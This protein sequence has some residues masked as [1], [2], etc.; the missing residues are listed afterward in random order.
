MTTAPPPSAAGRAAARVIAAGGRC[1]R[2]N[3]AAGSSHIQCETCIHHTSYAPITIVHY[4]C[5]VI[6]RQ[7][8]P[9]DCAIDPF[10]NPVY[11]KAPGQ[12]AQVKRTVRVQGNGVNII[13]IGTVNIRNTEIEVRIVVQI[14]AG[15]L[16][17]L[18]P[19]CSQV[20]TAAE[21]Q[22]GQLVVGAVQFR[23]GNHIVQV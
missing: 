23:Q 3:R 18:K 14:Q 12:S 6:D 16:V 15:K 13:K 21:I 11:I 2:G 4:V 10:C 17:I 5:A 9:F 20:W 7:N 1:Y 19:Q 8:V 22:H